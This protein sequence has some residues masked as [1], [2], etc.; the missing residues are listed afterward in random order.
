MRYKITWLAGLLVLAACG[1][2]SRI[3]DDYVAQR[4]DCQSLAEQQIVK[5]EVPGKAVTPQARNAELVTL[6]SDCM[7]KNNWQVATPKR[8]DAPAGTPAAAPA[9]I[10]VPA[11]MPVAPVP[12]IAPTPA[13]APAMPAPAPVPI[14]PASMVA[15]APIVVPPGAATY[16]PGLPAAP[17]ATPG[18]T[19]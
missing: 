13:P 6:F 15:P 10:P 8:E 1:E 5:Y 4:D 3:Q 2:S 16:Q 12:V 17:V 7:A 14:A 19:F 9:A 18:K 11:P